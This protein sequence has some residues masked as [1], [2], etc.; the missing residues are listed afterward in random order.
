[1][2]EEK[3]EKFSI[4]L[5]QLRRWNKVHNLTAIEDPK[6]IAIRHFLDSLTLTLC[7]KEK[8]VKVEGKTFCDVGS[9]AGFPGVPLSIYYGETLDITLIESVS[10]KCAFLEFLKAHLDLNYKVFCKRAESLN[11]Q[12]DYALCRA[13]G[14]LEDIKPMLLTLAKEGVFIMKGRDIPEGYD[15]CRITLRDIKDS[16]IIFIPK[17]K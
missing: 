2:R 1:M 5:E 12:F 11:Q 15:Y 17:I 9:G 3:L 7:F 4:Y 14:K 10:K 8:K 6:E 16:Y 13:L